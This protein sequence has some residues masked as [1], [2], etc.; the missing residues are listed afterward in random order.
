MLFVS[1][2]N[3]HVAVD[4]DDGMGRTSLPTGYG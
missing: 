4:S 1:V 3:I 2:I